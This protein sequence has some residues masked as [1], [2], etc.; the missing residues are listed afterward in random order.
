NTA[1]G[2]AVPALQTQ[3]KIPVVGVIG[4]GAEAAIKAAPAGP[5]AVIATEGTVKGGAYVRA[6]QTL[7]NVAV[8]QKAC[9][10]FVPMAGEGLID[11]PIAE[12]VAHRYLDP[13]L[14]TMP[15]PKCLVL[16]CTHF[17][18]LKKVIARVAGSDVKLV[19]SAMTTANA[20]AEI[21]NSKRMQAD[22]MFPLRS[23]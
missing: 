6:I 1:S 3:L 12:A 16:G 2:V 9:P 13:L 5:I 10:L 21:L 17:P 15:R 11:G 14:A 20:V 23:F 22:G 8:A 4:P 19:D 18:A 7:A